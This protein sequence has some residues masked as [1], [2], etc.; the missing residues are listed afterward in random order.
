MWP[1]ISV[2]SAVPML[3]PLFVI[4]ISAKSLTVVLFLVY[5]LS[6]Y[7]LLYWSLQSKAVQQ[8]VSDDACHHTITWFKLWSVSGFLHLAVQACVGLSCEWTGSQ[9]LLHPA[10]PGL[11][12]LKMEAQRLSEM[13][14]TNHYHK[15]GGG[16]SSKRSTIIRTT[17]ALKTWTPITVINIINNN[18]NNKVCFSF[19]A[20]DLTIFPPFV[21]L[22][23]FCDAVLLDFVVLL[24]LS[25]CCSLSIRGVVLPF[26]VLFSFLS[27][28][29]VVLFSFVAL[30]PLL[31]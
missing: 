25:L 16:D 24:F 26:A 10:E 1:V 11:V 23:S 8:Q 7:S 30:L 27:P 14:G 18:N 2:M 4:D 31:I 3:F 19:E 20:S 15:G 12:I 6:S 29:F 13:P 22:F 21:R 9:L 5:C 28:R 17:V